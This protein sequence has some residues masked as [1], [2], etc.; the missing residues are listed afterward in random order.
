M[1]PVAL[2]RPICTV[3]A[4]ESELVSQNLMYSCVFRLPRAYDPIP[5]EDK[6]A[7]YVQRLATGA[8]YADLA[9]HYDMSDGYVRRIADRVSQ[10]ISAVFCAEVSWPTK[11]E[12]VR[13]AH[14]FE[15]RVGIVGCVGAVDGTDI[16]I[17][18]RKATKQAD[19]NIKQFHSFKLHAVVDSECVNAGEWCSILLLAFDLI[20]LCSFQ[21]LDVNIGYPGS[22]G[23]SSIWASTDLC[24]ELR[25]N[26]QA[27][28]FRAFVPPHCFLVGDGAY[29]LTSTMMTPFSITQLTTAAR[30]HYNWVQS[31][32]RRCVEQAFGILKKMWKL[33]DM[34]TEH[35]KKQKIADT[36]CC[37]IMH[38]LIIRYRKSIA[39]DPAVARDLDAYYDRVLQHVNLI[40]AMEPQQRQVHVPIA[41]V[42]G[43]DRRLE[44]IQQV[45]AVPRV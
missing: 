24:A 4:G 8:S 18:A 25:A 15:Q 14:V 9:A 23:D 30:W 40:L 11:Q 39:I 2:P 27:D 38:N 32:A 17:R 26:P 20:F 33:L 37:V 5:A 45:Q 22:T 7:I 35:S 41:I 31:R 6:F 1:P 28:G 13:M 19:F 21:F 34:F 12:A 3:A 36:L 44:V 29:T 42:A 43:V 16:R 10:A